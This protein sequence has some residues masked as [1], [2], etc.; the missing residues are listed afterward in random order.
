MRLGEIVCFRYYLR[1]AITVN[2]D[3]TSQRVILLSERLMTMRG[4]RRG[5]SESIGVVF[6]TAVVVISVTLAGGLL[7]LGTNAGTGDDQVLLDFDSK[8]TAG[9][10]V[11]VHSGGDAVDASDLQVILEGP[12]GTESFTVDAG[13]ITGGDATLDPG[14]RIERSYGLTGDRLTLTV[15]YDESQVVVEDIIVVE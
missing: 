11:L 13:N 1:E 5:Q 7:F 14:E 2:D 4:R 12:S 10:L 9:T 8:T 3:T 15:V 6:M